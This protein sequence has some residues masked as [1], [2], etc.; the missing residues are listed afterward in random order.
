MGA[1]SLFKAHL[2]NATRQLKWM[3]LIRATT[4]MDLKRIMLSQK[5]YYI[6]Y[7]SMYRT[8][9]KWQNYRDGAPISGCRD[10]NAGKGGREQWI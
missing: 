2:W 7:D 1:Y 5:K 4:W 9:L 6:L 8:L 10:E 3:A